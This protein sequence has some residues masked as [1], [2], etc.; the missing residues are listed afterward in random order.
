MKK[1]EIPQDPSLLDKFTKEV[2]YA[3]DE[4]GN[5]TTDL[6]RGWEVKASALDLAWKDIEA[7]TA[8]AREKVQK[9]EAS[10]ILFFMELR[11]MDLPTLAGYTGFWQWTIKRHLKPGVFA[12]LSHA[13]LAKYAEVFEVNIDNL[14]K[15][16]VHGA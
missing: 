12:K 15:C 1:S 8:E 16:E 2:C 11:L 10:P 13:K 3:V 6:S 5:Y 9:G 14:K 4:T 7:R